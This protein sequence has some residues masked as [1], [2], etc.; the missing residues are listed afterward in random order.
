[1]VLESIG[2]SELGQQLWM[3]RISSQ[4]GSTELES[5][6]KI[7]FIANMHGN[8]VVGREVMLK[9]IETL[10][11]GFAE[12]DRIRNLLNHSQLFIMPT[13]NPDGFELHQ[14][15]NALG[16][17]L[18]RDF[19]D[20]MSDPEER[21]SDRAAET[22]AVMNFHKRHH[23]VT[24]LNFHGGHAC[25]NLPW[26]TISNQNKELKFGD[27]ALMT[28][29][30]LKYAA[31]N[32]LIRND[33][34]FPNGITYGFEFFQINGG[35]QDWADFY[36]QATHA[37]VELTREY[38]P[39]GEKLPLFW[40]QNEESLLTFSE[41][42]LVGL[43]LDIR[44]EKGNPVKKVHLKTSNSSRTLSWDKHLVH[45]TTLPGDLKFVISSPGFQ[46][47]H[48]QLIAEAFAGRFVE[49]R[50]KKSFSP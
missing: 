8:E 39:R 22:R 26:D 6:P 4:Q 28:S 5:K 43:H 34:R 3:T 32:P 15:F 42:S 49:I 10:L 41:E 44:D 25:I 50:L 47:Y 20:F 11:N 37:T 36:M 29:L 14:R 12:Q 45:K 19:P 30:S 18:N 46:D 1:M 7:L 27:D 24:S 23:F 40:Q 35:L 17:D 33:G 48:G 31:L 38:W 9:Y 21:L 2:E 16:V 13:M